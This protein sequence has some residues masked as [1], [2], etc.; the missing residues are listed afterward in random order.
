MK[1]PIPT[2][3]VKPSS[4]KLSGAARLGSSGRSAARAFVEARLLAELRR[5]LAALHAGFFD[6]GFFLV[7]PRALFEA[8]LLF[9]ARRVFARALVEPA[10]PLACPLAVVVFFFGALFALT[11]FLAFSASVDAASL[12]VVPVLTTRSS[13]PSMPALAASV[14]TLPALSARDLALQSP[15]LQCPL[16]RSVRSHDSFLLSVHLCLPFARNAPAT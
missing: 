4:L 2:P 16:P 11:V 9:G 15:P 10:S 3:G 5:D 14:K 13:T 12:T 6:A 8:T 1:L 7:T